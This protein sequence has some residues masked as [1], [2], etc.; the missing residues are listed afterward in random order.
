MLYSQMS[1]WMLYKQMSEIQ[2]HDHMIQMA[3]HIVEI[4]MAT[5]VRIQSYMFISQ[6]LLEYD[7][8]LSK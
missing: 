1:L 7:L 4:K 8:V 2:S 6:I 3:M 5:K